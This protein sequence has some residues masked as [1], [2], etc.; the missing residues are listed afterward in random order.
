[1]NALADDTLTQIDVEFDAEDYGIAIAKGQDELLASINA[2]LARIAE[3]GT[4]DALY[5]KYFSETDAE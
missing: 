2:T 1:M 5:A 4:L 3:D